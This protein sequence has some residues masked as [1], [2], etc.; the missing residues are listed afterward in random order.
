MLTCLQDAMERKLSESA[1]THAQFLHSQK[2]AIYLSINQW[3]LKIYSLA[4]DDTYI[5]VANLGE[6]T[7]VWSW[8][9]S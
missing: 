7:L 3:F 4:Q 5:D 1:Q 8:S 6:T 9:W 2:Q